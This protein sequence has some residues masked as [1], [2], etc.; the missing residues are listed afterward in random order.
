MFRSSCSLYCTITN[1]FLLLHSVIFR[2]YPQK[3]FKNIFSYTECA[4]IPTFTSA[5]I[6]SHH[7]MRTG[8]LSVNCESQRS[9]RE[10]IEKQ[11]YTERKLRTFWQPRKAFSVFSNETIPVLLSFGRACVV[12][13]LQFLLIYVEWVSCF[14]WTRLLVPHCIFHALS[15]IAFSYLSM[16]ISMAMRNVSLLIKRM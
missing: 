7:M 10:T 13:R 12:S 11:I 16:H 2:F 5:L 4:F 6:S 9:R 14:L 3:R 15:R 8:C 1:N